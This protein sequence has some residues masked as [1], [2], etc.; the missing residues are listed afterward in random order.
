MNRK[1]NI[2]DFK[3]ASY[4]SERKIS[5]HDLGDGLKSRKRKEYWDNF[6]GEGSNEFWK[7]LQEKNDF[8]KHDLDI[9]LEEHT[10]DVKDI[11]SFSHMDEFIEFFFKRN[12]YTL[13]E[14]YIVDSEGKR[15][16]I[17]SNFVIPFLK[18]AAYKLEDN[19]SSQN[20]KVTRDVLNSLLIALF[21]QILNIS[22]RT[23]ILEL[24]V[25]KEQN[26]LKGETG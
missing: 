15:K 11:D 8:S 3:D 23:L 6:I 25:L 26:M 18:F 4:F 2:T 13:P 20:L 14:F 9:F 17:F 12:D 22:Y 5:S 10:Y 1:L 16:P 24:Q 7:Y 21:Q 19:L